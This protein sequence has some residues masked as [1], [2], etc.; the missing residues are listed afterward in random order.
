MTLYNQASFKNS[1]VASRKPTTQANTY[2]VNVVTGSNTLISGAKPNRTYITLRS[3][4]TTAG[5]DLVY[6]Y[7]DNPSILSEGFILKAGEAVDLESPQAIYACGVVNPVI[8]SI[9]EGEG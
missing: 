4:A 7:F 6:D 3:T 1:R 5:D 2:K 8:C 9:D